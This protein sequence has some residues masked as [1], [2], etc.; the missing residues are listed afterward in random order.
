VASSGPGGGV[1][2]VYDVSQLGSGLRVKRERKIR[3]NEGQATKIL[4]LKEF[5]GDRPLRNK[6][7]ISL[8]RAM[9]RGTFRP[10]Q[11]KLITCELDGDIYRMNGQHTAWAVLELVATENEPKDFPIQVELLEYEA[12]TEY[13]MRMLYSS[14]DRGTSRTRDNITHSYLAGT[15]EF[16]RFRARTLRLAPQ[17][18]SLWFWTA[19]HDR[20]QHDA[21]AVAYLLRT[22]HVDLATKVCAFLNRLSERECGHM[23]RGSVAGAM[24]ATFHKAPQVAS[25]FWGAV[26]EGT[27]IDDRQDPRLKLRNELMRTAVDSGGGSRSEKKKVSQEF[28]FR[29]CLAAWNAFRENRTLQILKAT[30]RGKRPVVK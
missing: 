29:Q 23:M 18:F 22:D 12:D 27:G 30:E 21:D 3:L 26:A 25:G 17:G 20:L 1:G 15:E 19:R 14:I 24:F 5:V 8:A 2:E 7:V 4:E 11:V 16:G 28:M 13:D 6:H 9:V 10:E